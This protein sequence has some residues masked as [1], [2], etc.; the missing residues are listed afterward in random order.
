MQPA[1]VQSFRRIRAMMLSVTRALLVMLALSG[2]SQHA[3]SPS[4]AT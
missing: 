2:C 1:S 4:E 3:K